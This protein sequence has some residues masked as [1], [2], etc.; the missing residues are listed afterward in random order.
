MYHIFSFLFFSEL[1]GVVNINISRKN[2]W[3]TKKCDIKGRES[4]KYIVKETKNGGMYFGQY[5]KRE[6]NNI[7]CG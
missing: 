5:H 7:N 3:K 1:K 6:K 2:L 4:K